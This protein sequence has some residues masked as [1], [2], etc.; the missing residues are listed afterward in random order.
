MLYICGVISGEYGFFRSDDEG[1]S[2][3]KLNDDKHRFG[4]INSIEGDSR[5]YGRFYIGSGSF[6][7]I[8]GEEQNLI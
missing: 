6:G 8:V 4:D 3:Y 1:K 5:T 2:W 7:V